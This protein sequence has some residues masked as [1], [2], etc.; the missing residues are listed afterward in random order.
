MFYRFNIYLMEIQA[1]LNEWLTFHLHKGCYIP[2]YNLELGQES[3][4]A[5]IK[6]LNN[7][8]LLAAAG[9]V[10][11]NTELVNMALSIGDQVNDKEPLMV[12]A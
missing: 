7:K 10:T 9:L 1:C 4:Q 3:L 2:D 12:A 6:V 5:I 8:T 11:A